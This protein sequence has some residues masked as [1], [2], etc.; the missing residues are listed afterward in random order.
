MTIFRGKRSKPD[1][2]NVVIYLSNVPGEAPAAPKKPH[3][4]IQKGMQFDPQVSV[5][6][7]GTW[8]NF[9]N[10]DREF[11]NVF[12]RSRTLAFDLGKYQK[13]NPP[14]MV[15]ARA[16]GEIDVFCD[17]HHGMWAKILVVDTRFHTMTGPD[18]RFTIRRVPPGTYPIT[19][20]QPHGDPWSGEVSIH[21]G[22]ESSVRVALRERRNRPRHLRKTGAHYRPY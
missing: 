16:P 7:V 6:I 20:W 12:S 15:V 5:V 18:G 19:A 9:P 17:V 3:Q 21:P 2:S 10:M 14:K 8:L 4:I 1:H 13:G 22:G 11:H